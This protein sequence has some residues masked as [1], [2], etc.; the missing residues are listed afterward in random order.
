MRNKLSRRD[1]LY[2]AGG[3]LAAS[4]FLVDSV[5]A[6]STSGYKALVC[7]YLN[8]G[9]DGFNWLVPTTPAAYSTYATSR[10]TMGL[11]S[12]SLLSLT[13]TASDGN[14]YG[15]HPSCT[16]LQSLF[17]AGHVAFVNNVGPLIQPTTVAQAQ[18]GSVP[19][20]PQL[21]SHVDQT[22]A[23]MTAYPQSQERYGWAGRIADALT[24]QNGSP[25]LAFNIN[26][27]GT[28]YWQDGRVTNAYVLGT[29]GAPS[30]SIFNNGIYRGGARAAI[31]KTL[32][33]QAQNDSNL[34]VAEHA[35][36]WQNA[37]DK[38][39]FVNNALSA[40][41]DFT[42][43]FPAAAIAGND[44]YLSQQLHEVARVI[45]AQSQI[46]DARQIFFVQM[47][48]FDTHDGELTTQA[49]LL[50]YVSQYVNVFYNAMTEINQQNN[51]TLFTIS[52]FGRTLSA[53]NDGTDHGWGNHQ[54]VVGGAVNGGYYGQMPSLALG[55][56]NDFGL[57]RMVPTTSCDQYAATLANWF[58]LSS[59]DLATVFPNLANFPNSNLGF[60]A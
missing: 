32:L 25:N 11:S 14:A 42:T 13:G 34:M 59:S 60:V 22:T 1:F 55:S 33:A 29:N 5:S 44:W 41:G 8:G 52:D 45:K 20:P 30:T 2:L 7:L 38:V 56:P 23:W 54:M 57:G 17:N 18:S 10:S 12:S 24:A 53:N 31:A 43:T 58:G 47:G 28:N 39:A 26:V 50:G 51:V 37:A 4:N 46:G 21:F 40:S 9:N 16:E 48:G 27:G 49:Q 15:L 19:L 35:A 6:A 36:I 3:A